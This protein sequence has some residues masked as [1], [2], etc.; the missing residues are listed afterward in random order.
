MKNDEW[1][2]VYL[3]NLKMTYHTA[4]MMQHPTPLL[5]SCSFS[6][7]PETENTLRDLSCFGQLQ[8]NLINI[9]TGDKYT[10]VYFFPRTPREAWLIVRTQWNSWLGQQ[11]QTIIQKIIKRFFSDS[12]DKCYTPFFKASPK[13]F[14]TLSSQHQ[15]ERGNHSLNQ[16][17]ISS[18][19]FRLIK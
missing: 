3:Q 4:S 1:V 12:C 8:I 7:M 2:C 15:R 19:Q 13:K 10:H 14:I 11:I 5:S 16:S 18:D 17:N 9:R 6:E